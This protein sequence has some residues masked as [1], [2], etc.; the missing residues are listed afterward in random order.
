VLGWATIGYLVELIVS[1]PAEIFLPNEMCWKMHQ[2]VND[3][4]VLF[5][6][7]LIFHKRRKWASSNNN[8]TQPLVYYILVYSK[9]GWSLFTEMAQLEVEPLNSEMEAMNSETYV[10][11]VPSTDVL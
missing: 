8:Q 3:N 11:L 9:I 7:Q 6:L 1:D 2:I 10:T 4:A 5:I